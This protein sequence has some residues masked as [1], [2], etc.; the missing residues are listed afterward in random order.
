MGLS[1]QMVKLGCGHIVT[2]FASCKIPEAFLR[3]EMCFDCQ[4]TYQS[5]KNYYVIYYSDLKK[6]KGV[7]KL[8]DYKG[9]AVQ[10]DN[11]Q[12]AARMA[13]DYYQQFPSKQHRNFQIF[14]IEEVE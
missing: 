12:A 7:N 11:I 3:K 8:V 14:N 4:R 1:S 10:F 5:I 6:F 2:M 9:A 13:W